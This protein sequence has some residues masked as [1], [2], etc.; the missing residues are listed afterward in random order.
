MRRLIA[1]FALASS[2]LVALAVPVSVSAA[3][4]A[5]EHELI[6]RKLTTQTTG[7]SG[8][9]SPND[10]IPWGLDRI[11]S[12]TGR[13]NTFTYTSDGTG[14]KAYVVDSG[15]NASHGA[16]SGRVLPGWSYRSRTYD[17]TGEALASYNSSLAA[18]NSNPANGIPPCAYDSRIHQNVPSTYDGVRED[19][20]YGT[21]DNDGHGTHV[22]GTIGGTITGVAKAASIVPVRVLDSCG[23]GT[24]TMV[25][26]GLNW[27]LADHLPGEKAVVNM[28]IGFEST[29]TSIDTAIRNLLAE[30][31]VVVAAS[32][33]DG[34]SACG[35][36][37]AG[38]PGTIAVG[39]SNANDGEPSFTSFGECVDIFAPGQ[40]IISTWP[41]YLTATNT[42]VGETGTSMAA[43]HVTGAVARYLQSATVTA[44]TP[45]DVWNWLKINATCN[46]I[47]YYTPTSAQPSRTGLVRT[48][49]RLLAVEAPATVPC[50]PGN[51]TTTM[52]STSSVVTWE[53]VPAGNGSEITAYTA[54][55]TPG[56][57]S[58]TVLSGTTCT[59]TGLTTG[60]KYVVSVT[61]TNS[62]GVGTQGFA[63]Y[64]PGTP[65]NVKATAADKSAVVSWDDGTASDGPPITAFTATATPGG[66][67]C[68]V[69]SGTTC[70]ITELVKN[71]KYSISVTA[72]NRVGFGPA[73][74]AV[75]VTP[76]GLP[77]AVTSLVAA[78]QKNAL[79]LSWVQAA[80]DGAEVTYTATATPGGGTCTSTA[81]EVTKC[82]IAGLINGT[83][84][85]VSVI[86]E[87]TY[88]KGAETTAIG[89]A[90][91]APEVP[92]T[93]MS[94][95][96]SKSVTIAWSAITSSINVTYVVTSTP[97]NLT[98]ETTETSCTITGLK[99]GVNYTFAVTTKTTTGQV[100]AA[101]IQLAVRPGFIVKKSVVKKASSTLLSSLIS[102]LSTGK[103]TWS[104]SGPCAIVGT[105]LKA[106]KGSAS[107]VVT[108]KVAKKGK[109]PEM[110]TKL[111]VTV[112]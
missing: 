46:A 49:N 7:P 92:V 33:N 97:G 66:K 73:S 77:G 106:P 88:G 47:T 94:L 15:V 110:S 23:A 9:P 79:E 74:T 16:F 99:N 13:D 98:C 21:V 36:T 37:P 63:D 91:G 52:G 70:T 55:A 65:Q 75:S 44:A 50:A 103:K 53:E 82:S 58:C 27:I 78:T 109:Y 59:I 30:G 112:S 57:K 22:A 111:R 18:Y 41:K 48:P 76:G 20:D 83:E 67:S 6:A 42:Y 105:R 108:L 93:L 40:S 101:S 54:T 2:S 3:N 43:P 107:C 80:G 12:R 26:K 89:L 69:P 31:I 85:T 10:V 14:V 84:Y 96:G 4:I 87:N 104:E 81:T 24:E 61:A 35:I 86:G 56:G 17:L 25:L 32:G 1:V 11:D 39:A 34:G 5:P 28:S 72:K 90:D 19:S 8:F 62:S 51:I 64:L 95:V 38:T 45:T 102:S 100:A 71:T 60:T 68:T 29:A